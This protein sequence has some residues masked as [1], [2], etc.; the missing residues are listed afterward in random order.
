MNDNLMYE[1]VKKSLASAGMASRLKSTFLDLMRS[2]KGR[3]GF[4]IVLGIVIFGIYG[5]FAAPYNPFNTNAPAFQPPSRAHLLGT[6][7][8][9]EDIYSW[10]LIG[11]G[12]SLIVG[13]SIAILSALIGVLVG[14]IAGYYGGKIDNTLMRVVDVLL[15][16]PGFP[17]LVILSAFLPPTLETTILVLSILSWPFLSRVIRSQTLTLKQR[18]Y[19]LASRLSG[20]SGMQIIFKDIIPN[21]IPLIFINVIF[22]AV[23]GIVAQAG[24]AFFGLGDLRSVNWGTMLYWFQAED[25]IVYRAWWWLLPPGI[26]IVLLGVGA[27]FLANGIY[28]ITQPSRSR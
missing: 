12:T 1:K 13:F 9:G 25:G 6:D 19:I 18:Q 22:L 21:L 2:K 15:V 28:E 27:N 23:G 8:I 17:L 4:I 3:L 7:Y 14:V 10:F 26:G 16:I 20:M 24:L 11:T 5:H